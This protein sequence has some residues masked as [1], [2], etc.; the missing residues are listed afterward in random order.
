MKIWQLLALAGA[1]LFISTSALAQKNEDENETS[2]DYIKTWKGVARL[3]KLEKKQQTR[4]LLALYPVFLSPSPLSRVADEVLKRDAFKRFDA[5]EKA[6]RGTAK[7]LGLEAGV[8]YEL[9][10]KPSL[11]LFKPAQFISVTTMTY[12]YEGGVHGFY[13]STPYNFGLTSRA[14]QGRMRQGVPVQLR[15]LDFF[16]SGQGVRERLRRQIFDKL[17]ATKGTDAEATWTLDGTVKVVT[18]NQLENFVAER[19]GLRW[20]F[21]PYS[22]GPYSSG[23]IEVVLSPRELGSTFR[24]GL[25]R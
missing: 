25:L 20:F 14:V 2:N 11:M 8:K 17:R 3:Q 9:Q 21:S 23:E 6:S 10:V 13:Y 24:A 18:D 15:L 4:D 12:A 5:L 22:M 1:S 16:T 19:D 7:S